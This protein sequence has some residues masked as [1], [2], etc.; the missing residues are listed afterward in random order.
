MVDVEGSM[1]NTVLHDNK[2]D[3]C[4][5]NDPE[6]FANPA[7][8]GMP[9]SCSFVSRDEYMRDTAAVL[10]RSESVGPITILDAD[11][12]PT[13]IVSCPRD[14]RPIIGDAP[15]LRV[16]RLCPNATIPRYHSASAAGLDLHASERCLI[17]YGRIHSVAT[18]IAVAIPAGHEG[19]V[20]PRSGLAAKHGVTVL[21][22]PGT[23]DSDYRGEVKVLLINH[24]HEE[25]HIE[26]GDRIAQ[27]VIAPVSRVE[28][29]E[30][31]ELDG[32]ERGVGGFGSTGR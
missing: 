21:N 28:T 10:R 22:S 26:I 20:R 7:T 4:P 18:G 16:R 8:S 23:I 19:Q 31:V 2:N 13:A 9:C 5:W 29:E 32:T 24:G 1:R 3:D 14:E 30:V 15:T 6:T 12:E 27:L 11:G 17:A 25:F